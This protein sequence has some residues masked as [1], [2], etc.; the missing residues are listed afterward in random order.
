MTTNVSSPIADA[1]LQGW[2]VYHDHLVITVKG[3]SPEQLELR[4]APNLRTVK[5][6]TIHIIAGRISWFQGALKEQEENTEF[7]S[8]EKWEET[9]DL[10]LSADQIAYGLETS[11]ALIQDSVARWTQSELTEEI[12]LPWIGPEYPVTRPWVVWHILEHDLHH[13]GELTQTLGLSG[14][15][16]SLPPPP[17]KD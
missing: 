13:G 4:I 16:V 17:P 8:L 7:R 9:P 2:K 1:I 15:D 3:L 14:A 5:E 12:I 10:T 6:I 11:W